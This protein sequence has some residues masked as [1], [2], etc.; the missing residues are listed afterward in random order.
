LA[1]RYET[2]SL[3][4]E[5]LVQDGTIGLLRAIEKFDPSRSTRLTTFAKLWIE[6]EMGRSVRES[7]LVRLPAEK[8]LALT[9][10]R[11]AE[12][13]IGDEPSIEALAEALQISTEE[14]LEMSSMTRAL[15]TDEDLDTGP[16]AEYPGPL[17]TEEEA[18]YSQEEIEN[19]LAAYA[20]HRGRLEGTKPTE[21]PAMRSKRSD[22]SSSPLHARLLDLED[23]LS[24]LPD[25]LFEAVELVAFYGLP[26]SEAAQWLGGVHPNTARNRYA[27]AVRAIVDHLNGVK[28]LSGRRRR[29][30][31]T[32]ELSP[33]ES[34]RL[35][36]RKYE[37]F[38][39]QV[40]VQAASGDPFWE[41]M[42]IGWVLHED[43]GW[44]PL[45]SRDVRRTARAMRRDVRPLSEALGTHKPSA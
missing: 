20:E 24:R 35:V 44:V 29:G 37:S 2:P 43:E 18:N 12:E 39:E 8:A 17:D 32:S 25:D 42:E 11:R 5:D 41:G 38:L 26:P 36:V 33:V 6:G 10:L 3:P 14:V 21:R 7:S 45:V 9:R 4:L 15:I 1:A 13:Q 22:G 16:S 27:A 34:L 30:S 31:W 40:A 19:L 23:A 28:P